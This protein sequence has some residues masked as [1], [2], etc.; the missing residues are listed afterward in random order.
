[1]HGLYLLYWVQEKHTPPA[2]VASIL[3][4]GDLAHLFLEVPTGWV[5][6][7]FG[8][9]ASLIAG[10]TV[11]VVGMLFCWLGQGVSGLI[12]ASL[13]VALG[14]AFRSGADHALMYRSAVSIGRESQFQAI[15][16]RT[17]AVQLGAM[18]ALVLAGGAIVRA[19][20][21]GVG[22]MTEI[23][24]CSIGLAIACVMTEPPAVIVDT[25]AGARPSEPI[26]VSSRLIALVLPAAFLAGGA[27][28][29]VA[30]AVARIAFAPLELPVGVVT[31]LVGV[32]VFT[33]LVR[34]WTS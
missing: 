14:D 8:H 9:R 12:A 4:A 3:A 19:W 1:M 28:L 22:W 23:A 16:S 25:E 24:L 30:D 26:R 34:R 5:A 7:R 2:I 13:L 31:A 17:R 18:V 11:Q 29:V 20:G 21:Y 33:V 27:L 10:S 32:P 6:D 15:E